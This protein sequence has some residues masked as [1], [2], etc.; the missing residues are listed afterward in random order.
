MRYDIVSD[1]NN[2]AN[3]MNNNATVNNCFLLSNVK[4]LRVSHQD[5]LNMYL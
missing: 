3:D 2:S 5:D 1:I 4:L